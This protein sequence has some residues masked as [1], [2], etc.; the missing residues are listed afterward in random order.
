VTN[1][2]YFFIIKLHRLI[3]GRNPKQCPGLLN[4]PFGAKL[5]SNLASA[6]CTQVPE[7][8]ASPLPLM[9]WHS[10]M[11]LHALTNKFSGSST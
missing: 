11:H 6:K 8:H 1:K 10:L 9:T 4:G 3:K 2:F 5:C 7:L